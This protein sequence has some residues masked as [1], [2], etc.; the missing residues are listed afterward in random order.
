MNSVAAPARSL[1]TLPP[2]GQGTPNFAPFPYLGSLG[3]TMAPLPT[4]AESAQ[5]NA[6]YE[7]QKDEAKRQ[8]EMRGKIGLSQFNRAENERIM[9]D[10]QKSGGEG[11]H[12]IPRIDANGNMSF[13]F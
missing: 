6:Y 13:T 8:A 3:P 12:I 10:F 7:S 4:A 9:K 2:Q 11:G 1:P 5:M